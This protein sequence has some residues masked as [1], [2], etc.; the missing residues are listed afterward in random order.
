VRFR[1]FGFRARPVE[2][3]IP[4][5]ARESARVRDDA[6]DLEEANADSN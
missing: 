2:R 3:E 4:P 6:N 1:Q 5:R